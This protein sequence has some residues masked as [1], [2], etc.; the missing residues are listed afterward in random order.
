MPK[1]ILLLL[2]TP[3]LLA[4]PARAVA[5]LSTQ[6]LVVNCLEPQAGKLE[7][8]LFNSAEDFLK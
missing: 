5:Q 4:C 8:S 6:S 3:C 7:V 1:S 2:L